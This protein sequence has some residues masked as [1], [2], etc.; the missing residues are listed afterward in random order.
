MV[1]WTLNLGNTW[2]YVPISTHQR[3]KK[4]ISQVE[5]SFNTSSI[6]ELVTKGVFFFFK[7]QV[8]WFGNCPTR[9]FSQIWLQRHWILFGMKNNLCAPKGCFAFW[10]ANVLPFFLARLF[11]G[12]TPLN[13]VFPLWVSP[14]STTSRR[15]YFFTSTQAHLWPLPYPTH[16]GSIL[17][18]FEVTYMIPL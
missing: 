6:H 11:H 15:P 17:W 2:K 9:G 4:I 13:K 10:N 5:I 1:K 14:S 7:F 16:N 12:I 18:G 3:P 8:G